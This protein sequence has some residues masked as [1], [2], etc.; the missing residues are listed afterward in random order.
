MLLGRH[1]VACVLVAGTAFLIFWGGLVTSH[2]AGLSV[3]DWPTSY[4]KWWLWLHEMPGNVFWEHM[5]RE[6]AKIIGFITLCLAIW[7]S[8]VEPRFGVRVLGASMLLTVLLQGLLGGLTVLFMLKTEISTTHACL[9]QIFFCMT[10]A[11]AVVTSPFYVRGLRPADTPRRPTRWL[12][13]VAVAA[14]F[15]QLVAGAVM[16]HTDSGLAVPDFPHAYGKVYDGQFFPRL[17]DEAIAAYNRWRVS[18]FQPQDE[19]DFRASRTQI[20]LHMI[21]RTWAIGVTLALL[22]FAGHLLRRH[23]GD[24]TYLLGALALLLL[25]A[26]QIT[27]GIYTVWTMKA[28]FLTSAHVATGAVLLGL[29]WF[30]TLR[31]WLQPACA[32]EAA[33][34]ATE[35]EQADGRDASKGRSRKEALA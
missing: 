24:K 19:A 35:A 14:V 30:L 31:A 27:L 10:V 11:N 32:E 20:V 21:H 13:G 8:R 28:P 29:T 5:H 4:N 18:N 7:T 34:P 16:R 25:L 2:D 33:A 22:A 26:T 1:L 12:G 17:D 15:L 6:I 3:P 9:A 23:R